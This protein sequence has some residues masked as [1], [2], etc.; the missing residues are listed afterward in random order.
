MSESLRILQAET[1]DAYNTY[2]PGDVKLTDTEESDSVVLRIMSYLYH[3][4]KNEI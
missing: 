4:M 2:L 1:M 3:R